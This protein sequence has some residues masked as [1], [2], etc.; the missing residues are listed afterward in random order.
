VIVGGADTVVPP[1]EGLSLY[2]AAP[3][4]KRLLVVAGAGHVAA[5][6]RDPAR[7]E[8]TVLSFLSELNRGVDR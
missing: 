5:F 2:R 8:R 6:D 1:E 7:Y 4:P 3:G